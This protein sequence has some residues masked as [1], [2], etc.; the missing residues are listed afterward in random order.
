MA[1][2]GCSDDSGDPGKPKQ[3]K[4]LEVGVDAEGNGACL[5]VEEDLPP[6]VEKLPVVACDVPHTHEIFAE[7]PYEDATKPNDVYPGI[8]ALEAF[9][10][11]ACFA[12]FEPYV[13]TSAFD[14]QLVPTWLVPTLKGWNDEDDRTI[15]C[16]LT[17]PRNDTMSTSM[18]GSKI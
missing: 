15:L 1:V 5:L 17:D 6:E 16:V 2:A 14:S 9:A 7:V 10:E 18:R 11:T 8:S 4:V 3:Q 12:Q 13:G